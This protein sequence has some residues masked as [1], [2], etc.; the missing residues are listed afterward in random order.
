MKKKLTS[1]KLLVTL[2]AI[3]LGAFVPGLI[4]FLTILTPAYVGGE[5]AVDIA[6]AIAEAR[7][8]R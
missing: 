4:P 3:A 8:S 6:R 2:G 1:R 7:K 5:A